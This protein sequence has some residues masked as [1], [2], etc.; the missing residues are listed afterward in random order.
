MS[1]IRSASFNTERCLETDAPVTLK[2]SQSSPADL[3]PDRNRFKISR[4]IGSASARSVFC[5]ANELPPLTFNLNVKYIIPHLYE[6]VKRGGEIIFKIFCRTKNSLAQK[7]GA[8]LFHL[9]SLNRLNGELLGGIGLLPCDHALALL[10][11]R[12]N[13]ELK[14]N[15]HCGHDASNDDQGGNVT[16]KQIKAEVEQ[17]G[18]NV[19]G[20]QKQRLCIARALL[21]KPKILI[22]D[23]STSAVDTR[24]DALIRKAF[25]EEIPD[26]TKI[27]IAQRINSVEDADKII[28]IDGGVINGFGT[29]EELLK[30]N[31]I[32]KEVYDSQV[33]GSDEA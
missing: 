17:G 10:V 14:Q 3:R 25:R 15:Q 6:I 33:K 2:C 32:Y 8:V 7:Y 31:A 23:D 21:K 16:A 9:L 12:G 4:R 24:T 22:L 18:T 27:I 29:H 5:S 20:G 1:R 30:T 13:V 19:S 28:V 26:T 11:R